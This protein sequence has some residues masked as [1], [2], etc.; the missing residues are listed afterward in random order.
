MVTQFGHVLLSFT[1]RLAVLL[2]LHPQR[3]VEN[4]VDDKW[5]L[6]ATFA[7]P[8]SQQ[9]GL[10]LLQ[11]GQGGTTGTDVD[12]L[13]VLHS[14]LPADGNVYRSGVDPILVPPHSLTAS[15]H[16]VAKAF[17]H[18][19]IFGKP[20]AFWLGYPLSAVHAGGSE[21]HTLPVKTSAQLLDR[22]R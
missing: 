12:H 1:Q 5:T 4:L 9:I 21:A 2:H 18:L 7:G 15:H 14:P 3:E 13:P 19:V 22:R 17:E 10:N 8:I 11:R 16:F 20:G 6:Q